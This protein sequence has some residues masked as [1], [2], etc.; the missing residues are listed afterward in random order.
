MVG[1]AFYTCSSP[2][3]PPYTKAASPLAHTPNNTR[4]RS[5]D[6]EETRTILWAELVAIH[7]ALSTLSPH[8]WMGIFTDSLSSLQAIRHHH[9]NPCTKSAKHYHHQRLLLDSITDLLESRQRL[10]LSTTLHKIRAHTNIRG[11]RPC[12]RG[13]QTGGYALYNTT[14]ATDTTGYNRGDSPPST[15][16]G[17]VHG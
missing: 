9:N 6:P 11:Q 17:Y 4:N 12:G 13:R 2:T 14:A 8:N 16:L 7:T 10:S 15:L 1:H 5:H 3:L